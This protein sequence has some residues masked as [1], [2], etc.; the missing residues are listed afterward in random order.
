MD[1]DLL[2][3]IYG[4]V[5]GIGSSVIT[6][7]F[8]SWLSRRERVRQL[9]EEQGNKLQQIYLPTTQE[10][11]QY[12]KGERI[13]QAAGGKASANKTSVTLFGVPSYYFWI[14]GMITLL[15]CS[16]IVFLVHWIDNPVLYL[17]VAASVGFALTYIATKVLKP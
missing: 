8:Q 7:L 5:I 13:A 10:V 16:S 17:I 2:M 12:A 6:T 3:M 14:S 15:I 11:E 1:H 9:K 4:A